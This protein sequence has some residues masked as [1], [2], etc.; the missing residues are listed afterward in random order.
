M[1]DMLEL[2]KRYHI[3][4]MM[5]KSN[6]IKFVLPA[7]L[8]SSPFL[9]QK[10]SHPIVSRN[11]PEGKVWAVRDQDLYKDP[12]Q[13][14]PEVFGSELLDR[15][16]EEEDAH[17]KDGGA[18]MMAYARLQ[19]EDMSDQERTEITSALK[20]YCELDTLAMVMIYEAWKAEL[21]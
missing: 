20:R 7:I 10:Y 8:N 5:K 3:H 13:L 19:F 11:F 6:S 15:L 16:S 18:A 14:L 12:Y 17:L 2:V 9:Q 1:V 4:P 21:S